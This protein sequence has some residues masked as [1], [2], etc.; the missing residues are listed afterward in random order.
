MGMGPVP[1]HGTIEHG[2]AEKGLQLARGRR[3]KGHMEEQRVEYMKK[4]KVCD[5]YIDNGDHSLFHR[6]TRTL[7]LDNVKMTTLESILLEQLVSKDFMGRAFSF[8]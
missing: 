3:R 2:L 5:E 6:Y 7:I 1:H 4:W 8:H